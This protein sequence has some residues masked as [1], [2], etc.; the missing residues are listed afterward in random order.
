MLGWLLIDNNLISRRRSRAIKLTL[1]QWR[2]EGGG[3]PSQAAPCPGAEL[4]KRGRQICRNEKD[5]VAIM[6]RRN[7]SLIRNL[8]TKKGHH[9][10]L[11]RKMTKKISGAA[12]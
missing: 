11:K 6:K 4:L 3:E 9:F 8:R 5:G 2:S 10:V 12:F 1:S 7:I